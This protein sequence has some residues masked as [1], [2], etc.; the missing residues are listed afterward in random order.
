MRDLLTKVS[1]NPALT[2]ETTVQLPR[3]T[4]GQ[5]IFLAPNN[6]LLAV[7][8]SGRLLQLDP[9][10]PSA[11]PPLLGAGNAANWS[12]DGA[13]ILGE[14]ISLYGTNLGP[15]V[16]VVAVPDISNPL[17]PRYPETLGGFQVAVNGL[18]AQL[19][20]VSAN[21]INL[22]LPALVSSP[23]DV[24]ISTL[25]FTA[26]PM[27][28]GASSAVATPGIF[29]NSDGSAAALN[30]DGTLNTS[31]NPARV[32]DIISL[33]GTGIIPSDFNQV[34]VMADSGTF[35]VRYAG[36]APGLVSGVFQ[37]NTEISGTLYGRVPVALSIR[38]ITSPAVT[39]FVTP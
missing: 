12:I 17:S 8:T 30:Q 38:D 25:G 24:T 7:G 13:F 10:N 11:L 28:I 22:V 6:T 14:L 9:L 21:Q 19:L 35:P 20:Y 39:V 34:T 33:W 36:P 18:S 15:A 23:I 26:G 5:D 16:P 2:A 29:R 31:G 32:G 37:I 4:A 1:S 3:G 27:T